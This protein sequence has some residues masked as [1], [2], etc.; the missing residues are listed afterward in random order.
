MEGERVL[1]TLTFR[2]DGAVGAIYSDEAAEYLRDLSPDGTIRTRR[3]SDVEPGAD[4]RWR[5]R[6]RRWV[7]ELGAPRGLGGFRWR[8]EALEAEVRRLD[9][10]V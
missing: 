10:V 5:V 1:A 8:R 9:E 4:G 3:A 2:D 7:R 6:F